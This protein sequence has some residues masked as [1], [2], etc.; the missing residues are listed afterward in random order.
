MW[1]SRTTTRCTLRKLRPFGFPVWMKFN[2]DIRRPP[3]PGRFME[4]SPPPLIVINKSERA[5]RNKY[6]RT[7]QQYIRSKRKEI[8]QPAT[9]GAGLAARKG[10]KS[11][12][13]GKDIKS[14]AFSER[15]DGRTDGGA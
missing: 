4:T 12:Y 7:K 8:V 10:K 2:C 13:S 11:G 14:F 15:T 6:V 9:L 1:R 3:E 5:G